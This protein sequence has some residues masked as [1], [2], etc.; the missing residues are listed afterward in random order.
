MQTLKLAITSTLTFTQHSYS[1]T[2]L[3][4][5]LL[6]TNLWT[7]MST[8]LLCCYPSQVFLTLANW[9]MNTPKPIFKIKTLAEWITTARFRRKSWFCTP[10][11]YHLRYKT[12]IIAVWLMPGFWSKILPCFWCSYSQQNSDGELG[13]KPRIPESQARSSPG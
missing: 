6:S 7:P 10:S 12:G 3:L 9:A 4:Y 11:G 8:L 5:P 2:F 1:V 13:A